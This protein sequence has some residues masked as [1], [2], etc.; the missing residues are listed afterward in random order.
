M[1]LDVDKVRNKEMSIREAA[2]TFS[3]PRSSLG[4][5]LTKLKEGEIVKMTPDMG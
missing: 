4:D 3:A 2:H 1:K 5:R